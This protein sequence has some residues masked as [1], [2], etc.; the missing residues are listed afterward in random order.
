MQDA[1]SLPSVLRRTR[2]DI[3]RSRSHV[4]RLSTRLDLRDLIRSRMRHPDKPVD[5]L[6]MDAWG[7]LSEACRQRSGQVPN[8]MFVPLAALTRDLTTSTVSALVTGKVAGTAAA[9]VLPASA[10]IGAGATVLSGLTGT[11][12]ALPVIDPSF[13]AT[14][15]WGLENDPAAARDPSF[16][17]RTLT[18]KTVSVQM[19]I[20][21]RLL[22]NSSVDVDAMLRREIAAQLAYAIDTAAINGSGTSDP[23]GLLGQAQLEVVAAGANGAA[24][25]WDHVVELEARVLARAGGNGGALSYLV[26]PGLAKKMRKTPRVAGTATML[27]E[28]LDFLG[29]P[30][31]ISPNMPENLTKGTSTGVCAAFLFGDISEVFVG[32]WGPAAVDLIV[33]DFTQ[34]TAGRV[35]IIARADVGIAVRRI[36]AFAAYKDL[37]PA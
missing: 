17:Q 35:R 8:G 11:S 20:S 24:P 5:P 13:T 22:L 23:L 7:E 12:Y 14:G 9:A 34:S 31:R 30:A 16:E 4:D 32:F 6:G 18:P 29:Y 33:D 37:L 27:M 3:E 26:G 1:F 21:R 15:L 19:S 2:D 28:G 10:V 36:K 25:A